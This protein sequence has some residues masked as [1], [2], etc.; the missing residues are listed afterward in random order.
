MTTDTS[1]KIMA[2]LDILKKSAKDAR[3]GCTARL[4][5]F[6]AAGHSKI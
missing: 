6:S 3:L 1:K 4:N 5:V 2:H